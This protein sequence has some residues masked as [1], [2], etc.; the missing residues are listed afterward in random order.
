MFHIDWKT[1][2]AGTAQGSVT[3]TPRGDSPL[4]VGLSTFR[5]PGV[6]RE[7]AQGFVESD[8]YVAIEAADTLR[9]GA[10]WSGALGRASRIWR[11]ALGNDHISCHIR[12]QSELGG[13][14]GISRVPL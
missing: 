12:Q 8:G 5:I 14:P 6:T 2:P 13:G 9:A 11:D 1:A 7:N 10:G 4:A 3:V